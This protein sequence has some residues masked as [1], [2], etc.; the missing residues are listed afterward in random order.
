MVKL[1]A[2]GLPG[3]EHRRA[4]LFSA[5]PYLLAGAALNTP[6]AII[7]GLFAGLGRLIGETGQPLDVVAM[8]LAA[9]LSA[10]LMQQNFAGRGFSCCAYP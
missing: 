4:P 1:P 6:A 8:A 3:D 9:G 2:E 5:A 7:V 10:M